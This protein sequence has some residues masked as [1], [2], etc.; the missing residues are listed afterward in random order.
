[1]LETFA[2]ILERDA[3]PR[4]LESEGKW[5]ELRSAITHDRAPYQRPR[6][7]S[8]LGRH[9][10]QVAADKVVLRRTPTRVQAQASPPGS[11]RELMGEPSLGLSL[12]P[13]PGS[14]R[15]GDPP[16]PGPLTETEDHG[17]AGIA[18]GG[19]TQAPP[20]PHRHPRSAPEPSDQPPGATSGLSRMLGGLGISM[21]CRFLPPS[22]VRRCGVHF[23]HLPE[24]PKPCVPASREPFQGISVMKSE[25]VK[26][27]SLSCVRLFATPWTVAYQAPP[28][29][30]FSRQDCWSGLPLPSP[31]DLPNPGIE[32]GSPALQAD[33]LPSE[34]SSAITTSNLDFR[35]RLCVPSTLS[36]TSL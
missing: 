18:R 25:V 6:G 34:P 27:K 30:G 23:T 35:F 9:D 31:G 22:P 21:V 33:A 13:A 36:R 20:S 5:G 17:D 10:T 4:C 26:V 7:S 19:A 1:M 8:H 16:Y 32:R 15:R 24:V 12:G 3:E 28:S 14:R 2:T 11:H 29:M